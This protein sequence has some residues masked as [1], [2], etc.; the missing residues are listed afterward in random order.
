MKR[1]SWIIAFIVGLVL[2]V[3]GDR[4]AG[5]AG[6][7]GKRPS[8][9]PQ[10]SIRESDLPPETLAGL[11]DAQK[12]QVLKGVSARFGS[13]RPAPARPQEDP[14]AVYRI[15]VDDSPAKGPADA[16]VTIVE[17]SDFE[18][19][20]CK[21]V[22][23][24]MKQIEETY[25]GKVRFVFKHNPLAFHPK[26]LPAAIAAEEARAQGGAGKFWAMHDR[27]F[28]SAPSLDRAALEKAA[29]DLG[30]DMVAFRKA[31]DEKR[32]EARIQRDQALVTS[33]GAGGTPTFFVNGRK[34][35]GAMPFEVFKATIDE[36]IRKAEDVVRSGV[37]AKEL[38]A[39]IIEKG[40][41]APAMLPAAAPAPGAPPPAPAPPAPAPGAAKV[42][43]RPDDP[44]RGARD[45]TVTVV[46]F[47]DFQCPFC[48]RVEPTLAQ[49][50]KEYPKDVRVVWK[51]QPLPFHPQAMPAALASEAAR[52]QGRFWEMHERLFKNQ[53]SLGPSQYE[54]WAKEIGLEPRKFQA[55]LASEKAKAR[56]QEDSQLGN[57]VGAN[58]TPTA[59]VNCRQVVGA[60]PYEAFK[61]VVDEEIAKAAELRKSGVKLDA[62]FYERVC[63]ENVKAA[64]K[65]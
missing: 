6:P 49:L 18:C 40:A 37:P 32:H 4:M 22:T 30:L 5:G 7:A 28:E 34:I 1:T 26:A 57:S 58:G 59:F 46:L 48:S 21:R 15:P 23:P 16:L 29:Q 20:F 8:D 27:L 19:P 35:A 41:T 52:E 31:L 54:Q 24:T 51:H 2:G 17:S 43:F 62:A 56:I 10:G 64:R 53:G 13:Q 55:S 65:N 38:Y 47:S 61:R 63:D 12:Y 3:A 60:V 14:K 39:R 9:L 33:V 36:E 25:A 44:S 42:G 45:A 11:T 50:Q